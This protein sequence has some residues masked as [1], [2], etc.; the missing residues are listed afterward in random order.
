[1]R[2]TLYLKGQVIDEPKFLREEGERQIFTFSIRTADMECFPV[3]MW[4][5][6]ME[7][8]EIEKGKTVH[9]SGHLQSFVE[10]SS[11]KNS[12]YHSCDMIEWRSDDDRL[13]HTFHG[14]I[15]KEPIYSKSGDKE[16]V[17]FL[18]SV[19][20]ELNI[21]DYI[22]CV[23]DG[24][25][26]ELIKKISIGERIAVVGGLEDDKELKEPVFKVKKTTRCGAEYL[27]ETINWFHAEE[28]NWELYYGGPSFAIF[29]I[30]CEVNPIV[31]Y[32]PQTT[33]IKSFD[34]LFDAI[35]FYLAEE[36]QENDFIEKSFLDFFNTVKKQHICIAYQG[37]CNC[38]LNTDAIYSLYMQPPISERELLEAYQKSQKKEK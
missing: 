7:K 37:D 15:C 2:T 35:V 30:L 29:Q 18:L 19:E 13:L 11:G 22:P 24:D 1:M 21:S 34:F 5:G 28:K 16:K 33:K 36:C 26:V 14:Y 20:R 23:V 17:C 31:K 38:M 6:L 32:N 4:K 27:K 3:R 25:N 12:L 8:F 9:L 10:K